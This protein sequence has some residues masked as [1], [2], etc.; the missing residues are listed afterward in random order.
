MGLI[1]ET[2]AVFLFLHDFFGCLP[3]AVQLLVYA[4]FGGVLYISLLKM[5]KN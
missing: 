5:V 2:S 1:G 3:V 4:S